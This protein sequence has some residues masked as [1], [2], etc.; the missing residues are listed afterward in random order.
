M[1][2]PTEFDKFDATMRKVLS[3]SHEELK[4][5]EVKWKR[6]RAKK[7]P[8]KTSPASRASKTRI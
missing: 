1:K 7:K 2:P 6:E 3:V 4:R 8:A 5:R